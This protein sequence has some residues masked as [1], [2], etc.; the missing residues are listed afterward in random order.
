MSCPYLSYRESAQGKSFDEA[1]AYCDAAER[2]VQPMRADVCNDRFEL[3]HRT[4]C[5]IYVEHATD[6]PA[7]PDPDPDATLEAEES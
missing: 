3:D 6:D 5:E 4:D 7:V 1:R 2:F